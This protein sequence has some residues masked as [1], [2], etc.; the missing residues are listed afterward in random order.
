MN[1]PFIKKTSPPASKREYLFALALNHHLVKSAIWTV[2]NR[3]PQVLSVG[4]AVSWD[5]STPDSLISA[6]DQTITD[7]SNHLDVSGSI[8]PEKVIFGLPSDWLGPEK[9]LPDKLTSLKLV[10][11]KLSLTAVGFVV[12]SEAVV[13]QL[14]NLE[15]VPPTAVL[16]GVWPHHLEITLLRLGKL[17]GIQLVKRSS[18]ITADLIE[19]LSR[20]SSIDMLPSRILLYDSGYDLEEIKQQLL[21]HPWQSPQTHLPFLHFPKIEIL[22]ND[23]TIHSIALAGGAE[24]ANSNLVSSP[25]VLSAEEPVDQPVSN[26]GFSFEQDVRQQPAPPPP[27]VR[28]KI[29]LH[30]PSVRLPKFSRPS[31]PKTPL[32]FVALA[33]GGLLLAAGLFAAYWYLPKAKV[34]LTLRPLPLQHQFDLIADSSISDLDPE[35]LKLPAQTLTVTTTA[36]KSQA[37]TGTKLIGDKATGTISV[38]NGTPLPKTFPSGTVISTPSGLKFAFNSDVTVSPASGSADP[39]SYQP[40]TASVQVTAQQIGTDSNLTAGSEFKIGTFS[41]LDYVAK[42]PSAFSGGSSRQVAAVSKADLAKLKDDLTVAA[43]DQAKNQLLEQVTSSQLIIPESINLTTVSSVYNHQ[44]DETADQLNLKLSLKASALAI[45][46]SDLD[47]LIAEQIQSRQPPGYTISGNS[48]QK[49]TVKSATGT[50]SV[51]NLQVSAS[52]LPQISSDVIRSRLVGKRP[53]PAISYLQ[54]LTGVSQVDL[55]F[56]PRLPEFMLTMPRISQNIQLAIVAE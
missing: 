34:T 20:Y 43:R 51:I 24:V 4:C 26:L 3:K 53:A 45:S 37:T 52:L 31:L 21:S 30:L 2:V 16:V 7:A 29:S 35:A 41:S 48:A 14:Q 18:K 6:C 33:L 55:T 47:Q 27:A 44:L 22:P 50:A 12:T 23:F 28:P 39:N 9:I 10:T 25:P 42:N 11:E 1:L 46:K 8:Q 17:D 38:I 56:Y 40:G 19:G 32:L 15:G 54:S 13:R 49:F 5:D 36:E